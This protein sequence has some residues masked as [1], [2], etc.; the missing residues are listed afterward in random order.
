[1]SVRPFRL[2]A[3]E[4]LGRPKGWCRRSARLTTTDGV[5]HRV[6]GT[7]KRRS[8]LLAV[9]RSDRRQREGAH[10]VTL[11]VNHVDDAY[12]PTLLDTLEQLARSA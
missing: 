2:L 4:E 6:S 10:V 1:M 5:E 3:D 8:S 11:D 7:R 12:D 9:A